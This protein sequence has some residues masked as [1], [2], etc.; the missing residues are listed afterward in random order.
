MITCVLQLNSPTSVSSMRNTHTFKKLH[1][2]TSV[3]STR[4]AQFQKMAL[5]KERLVYA[6]HTF[7][8][9]SVVSSTRDA[10]FFEKM[11]SR[12][13]ETTT[14]GGNTEPRPPE[15]SPAKPTRA[16]KKSCLIYAK[17][18]LT[19]NF[20]K[21]RLSSTRNTHTSKCK[22]RLIYARRYLF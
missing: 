5:F 22:C 14:L 10:I 11:L 13:R 20:T 9:S 6:K 3:S 7:S 12:L 8:K 19:G 21:S 15:P 18:V 16:R 2:P 4:N 1:S 17:R